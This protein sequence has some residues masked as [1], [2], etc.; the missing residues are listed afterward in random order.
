MMVMQHGNLMH[1]T[2]RLAATRV[3]LV[4]PRPFGVG[5]YVA[6]GITMNRN[7]IGSYQV[8]ASAESIWVTPLKVGVS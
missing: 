3:L 6:S 7:Y 5:V 8:T 2:H 1:S 4:G